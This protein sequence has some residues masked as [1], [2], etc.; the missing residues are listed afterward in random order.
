MNESKRLSLD[1]RIIFLAL[2]FVNYEQTSLVR[3]VASVTTATRI[4]Q[5][6]SVICVLS[7]VGY[8]PDGIFYGFACASRNN[9]IRVSSVPSS[10]LRSTIPWRVEVSKICVYAISGIP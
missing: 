8:V 4:I 9:R 1:G 2:L 7:V 5:K 3:A 10:C 6:N